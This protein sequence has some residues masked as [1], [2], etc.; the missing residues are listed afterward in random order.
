MKKLFL[1][2][3]VFTQT[4]VSCSYFRIDN[5]A[6]RNF[7]KEVDSTLKNIGSPK[8]LFVVTSE[9][10]ADSKATLIIWK[11]TPSGSWKRQGDIIDVM[12]GRSGIGLGYSWRHLANYLASPLKMEGDG[13]TPMGLHLL[14]IKFGHKD[15]NIFGQEDNY[16]K[17]SNNTVCVDDTYSRYY[18]RI[19]DIDTQKIKNKDWNSAEQ[20]LKEPLYDQGIEVKYISNPDAKSG[21]CIFMHLIDKRL[22]GTSGCIAMERRD[23]ERLFV[24]AKDNALVG[25]VVMLKS[26]YEQ[27][28]ECIMN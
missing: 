13:R 25:L 4:V 3:F 11:R 8:T 23:L 21:S 24:E 27:H 5:G 17:I 15:A 10:L 18:N 19:I 12:I 22:N 20:M 28:Q 6:K 26:Q 16:L 9:Y 7:C 14:G 2:F 1:L